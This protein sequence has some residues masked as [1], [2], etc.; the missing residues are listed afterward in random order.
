MPSLDLSCL[1][2][3]FTLCVYVAGVCVPSCYEAMSHVWRSKEPCDKLDCLFSASG[4][5][6][7]G[8]GSG[9]GVELCSL[10][11]EARTN[12]PLR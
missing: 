12:K 10:G 7:D 2:Y 6:G 3:I 1:F 9:S 8:G 11:L 5:C 4:S